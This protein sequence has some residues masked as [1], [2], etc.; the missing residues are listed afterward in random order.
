MNIKNANE[1]K[2]NRKW[3]REQ[4]EE[5]SKIDYVITWNTWK[6]LKSWRQ[7]KKNKMDHTK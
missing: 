6:R 1:H 3:T 5:R 7:L 4:G 2:F